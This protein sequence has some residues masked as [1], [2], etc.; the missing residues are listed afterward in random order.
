M[1]RLLAA[2]PMIAMAA[3]A[4]D[5]PEPIVVKQ[6]LRQ[7]IF[8]AP[9]MGVRGAVMGPAV[10]GAPYS[11]VEVAE[12]TQVL[13]DGTHIDN[14]TQTNVYRDSEGRVRR[15]TGDQVNI[16][17]P[18]AGVSYSLDTKAQTARKMPV[19]F[20]VGPGGQAGGHILVGA[21]PGGPDIAYVRSGTLGAIAA[22]DVPL[23]PPPPDFAAAVPITVFSG[24]AQTTAKNESL[25]S[26]TIEGVN[27]TGTR[28]TSTIEAGEIG[29]DRPI[30]IVSESWYSPE[31]QTV[32]KSSHS[33]PRMGQ[34]TFALTNV[35]RT[36]PSA[37]LFQV[38]AGYQIVVPK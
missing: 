19:G 4:Q 12:N 2:I 15:E 21:N 26:Q 6:Q 38:P 11:A 29:N 34:E 8:Q 1:Y 22:P 24:R 27:A 37:D 5:A 30:Q 20:Y 18:V 3:L 25:E 32:V 10:K 14:K 35:S 28:T 36:E 16:W 23:P 33:D 17:D 9:V 7:M 31:L 13:A